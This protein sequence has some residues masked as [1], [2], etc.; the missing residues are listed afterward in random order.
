L[1]GDH[2]QVDPA[3]GRWPLRSHGLGQRSQLRVGQQIVD[4]S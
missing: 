1:P 2:P 4:D 3:W